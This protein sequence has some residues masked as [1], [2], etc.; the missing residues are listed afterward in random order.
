MASSPMA[1]P[2]F[3]P[4]KYIPPWG[5]VDLPLPSTPP[6]PPSTPTTGEWVDTEASYTAA[7]GGAFTAVARFA[8]NPATET[9]ATL[10]LDLL[11]GPLGI[12]LTRLTREPIMPGSVRFSLGAT[13]YLDRGT[14]ILYNSANLQLGTIDYDTGVASLTS[15]PAGATAPPTITACL[16]RYGNWGAIAANFRTLLA[17]LKPEALSITVTAEDGEQ[18]T[19]IA[20]ADGLIEGEGISGA[21]DYEFGLASMFFGADGDDPDYTGE[22]PI[23]QVWI[24]RAVDP[25]TLRYNAVS[26]SY[27][28]LDADILG[29]D[30]VRLPSDGRVPIYRAGDVALIMHTSDAT[31]ATITNGGTLSAG[32]TRLAWARVIDDDGDTVDGEL[33]TLD[34]ANGIV[35]VPDVSGLAQPLTLRHTIADLRMITD[36]QISGWLTLS[37]GLTHDFPADDSLVAGC[38]LFGDRRARVS[39]VWD[40]AAWTSVWQDSILGSAATATLNLIDFPITVTNEGCDTDRWLFRCTNSSTNAWELISENRGLVWSGTYAVGGADVAPINARTRT[41]DADTSQWIGGTPYLTIPGMANGGGWSTG[42]CVR[43]N[44]I[45]A[46][47]DFWV[48]R[49]IQQSDEPLDEGYDG[50]EIY[51]LGNVDR[52]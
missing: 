36:A 40:Q 35:T 20:D 44:T 21:V 27:L 50:V 7:I 4:K 48:A 19:A 11:D 43:I 23:P 9:A 37:R 42:N 16:T 15:W 29:I 3:A 47:A 13:A 31:P 34:R 45:G 49:S 6:P 2:C 39:A 38:L 25:S 33:Y 52:P 10:E 24:P 41:W 28:P 46:I 14:G 32:R 12:D 18:L 8:A 1:V 5:C 26:Y 30:P 17:P 51:A 22:P